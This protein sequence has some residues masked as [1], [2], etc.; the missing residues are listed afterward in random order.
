MR[1]LHAAL[2][3][4]S[5]VGSS[6]TLGRPHKRKNTW[7][8]RASF[9]G[10]DL[11]VTAA[12]M[13]GLHSP[14]LHFDMNCEGQKEQLV[15]ALWSGEWA[16]TSRTRFSDANS[17]IVSLLEQM[18]VD[19]GE[20]VRFRELQGQSRWE[21]VFHALFR[22]RSQR[23]VPIETAAL[24]IMW[25]YYRVPGPVWEVA[26]YFSKIVM[27][28]HWA[29]RISDL[30]AD[31]DPGPTYAVAE[32]ISAAVFDNLSIKVGYSSYMTGGQSGY[33][34]DMTNWAT[35]F[36]P[37]IAMPEGFQGIDSYLSSGG[38]FRS[39]LKFEDF[40]DGFGMHAPDIINNQRQRWISYL[41]TAGSA[42]PCIWDESRYDS[43][44][45][46]TKFHYHSPIFD[47]LQS[48]YED[49]NFELNHMR[50][51]NYHRWSDALMVGGDGLSYMRLIHR[52][53]QQPR[54][55]LESKPV[56]MPRLGENP[57][58]LFHFMHGDW[59]I[60]S[61][62]ILRLAQV[63]GNRQVKADPSIAD[64][65]THQHFVRI[66]VQALA[67]YVAEIAHTG[68]DY[69][70]VPQFLQAAEANLSFAYV[71]FFLYMFGFKYL[72]YR[73]AVRHNRSHVLDLLWRENL[74]STR[75]DKANK[76]NYRQM[77]VVLVYW[78]AA[79]IEPLQSFYHNT[80][81]VRW[82]HS[83]VGWDMPIEKLNMWMKESIIS[84]ISRWQ[85]CQFIR[86]L[87]FMQHV[88]R[89]VKALVYTNRQRDS[90][91]LKDI[92]V[93]VDTIKAFLRAR[94]GSTFSQATDPSD[95]NLLDVDMTD[96]G[97]LRRA[98]PCAPFNQ[99]RGAYG[100][101]RGY[102]QKQIGKL[103]PWHHWL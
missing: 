98:R 51:S 20:A 72:E 82:I 22:A 47:R 25:L 85:I 61:P 2:V 32:G 79:L 5:V 38:I 17:A 91:S 21:G 37:S 63:V 15:D 56:V 27:S 23:W 77:S 40:L 36:L 60:W 65:N 43:P 71:V 31:R 28:K 26:A 35:V 86:R 9:A 100:G 10:A 89:I 1:P 49:V 50:T 46:Q 92:R 30:G 78:G 42:I 73:S 84:N 103:C 24:S 80:R 39:D 45:P 87:N 55:Y 11:I 19:G 66:V 62:L 52:L 33:R 94:I 69:E 44:F 7:Y 57:H 29:E 18:T 75:T 16:R 70:R 6:A 90:A 8:A 13:L 88:I 102:V 58:G 97:G 3:L 99:I 68:T 74:A 95:N 67:E 59:R 101:Y 76:V 14:Q 83:H 64:F 12:Q 34:I 81:T 4:L 53:S 41:K 96:W 54:L 93:D 48:S